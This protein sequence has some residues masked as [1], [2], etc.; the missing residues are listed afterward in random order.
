MNSC[1]QGAFERQSRRAKTRRGCPISPLSANLYMRRFV[2]GCVAWLVALFLLRFCEPSLPE[3]GSSCPVLASPVVV[4]EAQVVGTGNHMLSPTICL[5][6]A[7]ARLRSRFRDATFR[8]RKCDT[9]SES[10]M[11]QIRMSGSMSEMW[12]RSTSGGYL[13][14]HGETLTR[15][16]TEA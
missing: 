8:V 6:H 12:K 5:Q 7:V 2:L 11:R 13:A 16:Q 9:L 4:S 3:R 1:V 14:T 15:M 10:R